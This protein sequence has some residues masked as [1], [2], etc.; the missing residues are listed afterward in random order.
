MINASNDKTY[1]RGL[2]FTQSTFQMQNY[3]N[4]WKQHVL[5]SDGKLINLGEI[6]QL[7]Y[8]LNDSFL[9]RP[10]NEGKEFNGKIN[11]F[12]NIVQW[13]KE[14]SRLNTIELNAKTKVWISKVKSIEKEWR[15][16][17]VNDEII[18]TS[19]YMKNGQLN[20]SKDDIPDEMINF[21]QE[22]IWEYR[23][24]DV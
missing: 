23:L 2:F 12:D 1:A 13:S 19:R 20:E 22:R 10:N 5:N 7:E 17:V 8:D 3:V 21:A 18:S 11:S 15:L 9:I 16:F 14:I 24:N 4:Q 6:D